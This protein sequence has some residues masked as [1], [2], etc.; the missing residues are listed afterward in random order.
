MLFYYDLLDSAIG[1][2]SS[3][4]WHSQFHSFIPYLVVF[5]KSVVYFHLAILPIVFC[6]SNMT[7]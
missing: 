5:T 2:M 4:F 1:V 6:Y 7:F 3:P